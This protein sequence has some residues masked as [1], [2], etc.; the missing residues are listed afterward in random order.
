MV[1][2]P[3]IGGHDDAPS[4]LVHMFKRMGKNQVSD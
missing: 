3:F 2:Y 1:C 4:R